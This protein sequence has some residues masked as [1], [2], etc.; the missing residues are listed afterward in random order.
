VWM[1]QATRPA[2][3]ATWQ[4]IFNTIWLLF[5][6]FL[7]LQDKHNIITSRT[8]DDPMFSLKM[9]CHVAG[10]AG[11]VACIIHTYFTYGF[12]FVRSFCSIK[13]KLSIIISLL[14]FFSVRGTTILWSTENDQ[15]FWGLFSCSIFMSSSS[16][17]YGPGTEYF[18]IVVSLKV[19]LSNV[20]SVVCK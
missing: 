19:T 16:V 15:F 13:C 20:K 8:S 10:I 3:P 4:P 18:I 7:T 6:N 2:I 5:F 11:L 12:I 17:R 1:M 14:K 9:G